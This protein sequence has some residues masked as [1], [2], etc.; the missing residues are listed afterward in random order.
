MPNILLKNPLYAYLSIKHAA[1][2][3]SFNQ[4]TEKID[5]Q[6]LLQNNDAIPIWQQS[7]TRLD[8]LLKETKAKPKTLLN[9]YIGSDLTRFLVLP[10]QK[11]LMNKQ[12]K[13]AYATA[14]FQDI[15]G[16]DVME[17]EI[18][19]HNN[20]PNQPTVIA[21]IDKNLVCTINQLSLKNH[22]KL[23]NLQPYVTKA[24]NDSAKYLLQ[25]DTYLAVI[26]VSRITLL[27]IKTGQYQQLRSHV[28]VDNWQAD[29]KKILIR[30]NALNDMVCHNILI[31]SLMYQDESFSADNWNVQVV[32]QFKVKPK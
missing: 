23:N 4:L 26:E 30:E 2:A 10:A 20:A 31:Y 17:W 22:F 3:T 5:H 14:A 27:F 24:F 11:M 12:E 1:I 18:K 16:A 21:A 29:L 6:T 9:L 15:Y 19:Y 8:G 7:C 25:D 28:I 32:D 13:I